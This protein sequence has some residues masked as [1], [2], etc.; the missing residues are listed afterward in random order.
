M[1]WTNIVVPLI[2]LISYHYSDKLFY[3]NLH[4]RQSTTAGAPSVR[5]RYRASPIDPSPE[6]EPATLKGSSNGAKFTIESFEIE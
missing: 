1:I 2:A 6:D 3:R 4:A 5:G